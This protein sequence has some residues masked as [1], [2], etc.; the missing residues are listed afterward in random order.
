[1]ESPEFVHAVPHSRS[2]DCTPGELPLEEFLIPMDH[3]V[4]RGPQTQFTFTPYFE[5]EVLRKRS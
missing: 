1:M 5:R 3:E 2:T 4:P